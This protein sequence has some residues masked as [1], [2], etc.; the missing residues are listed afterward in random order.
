MLLVMQL[1]TTPGEINNVT[2]NSIWFP[3]VSLS[4]GR[5]ILDF[6]LLGL[7][8]KGLTHIAAQLDPVKS[9]QIFQFV[10]STVITVWICALASG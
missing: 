3:K 6:F 1:K 5:V 9:S 4:W 2:V 8:N 10:V 7:I